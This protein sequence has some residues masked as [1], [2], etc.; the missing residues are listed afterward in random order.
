MMAWSYPAHASSDQELQV[1]HTYSRLNAGL[2][3]WSDW[4]L[5]WKKKQNTDNSLH[6]EWHDINHFD[7]ADQK[8]VIGKDYHSSP[9][10]Q[11]QTE[12]AASTAHRLFPSY[13]LY[14]G[15][16][17]RLHKP[18]IIN[19][20]LKFSHF[21]KTEPVT[22]LNSSADSLLFTGR[23]DYYTGN[24]LYSYSLYF[25][26]MQ[27]LALSDNVATHSVKLAYIY[28]D[29]NNIYLSY[30]QGDEID[31]DPA[32]ATLSSSAIQSI[33]L[34]GMH[35]MKQRLAI[36]YTVARHTVSSS[37]FGYQRNEL[38]IGIRKL[39]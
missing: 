24:Y 34:G 30:A 11:Y 26:H 20:G 29:I 35:W 28:N 13:T 22:L 8:I 23:L 36:V 4:K 31:F 33:V 7:V 25:T 17:S 21:D 18:L 19:S 5:L 39:Y 1:F 27:G 12:I 15:F 16:E 6:I 38:S 3:D 10:L 9:T 2:S 37:N 32:N 14:A